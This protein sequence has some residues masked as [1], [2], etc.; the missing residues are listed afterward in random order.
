M[1]I[2]KVLNDLSLAVVTDL[3]VAVQRCQHA[4][5]AQVLA[6]RL[7]LL[8]R[9]ATGLAHLDQRVPQTVRIEVGQAGGFEAGAKDFPN[10]C[11]AGPVLRLDPGDLKSVGRTDDHL[12][13]RKQRVIVAPEFFLSQV[14]HPIDDD[15]ADLI[16]DREENVVKDLLNFVFTSRAS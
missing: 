1:R 3:P 2:S 10:R 12:R 7:E 13:G 15:L 5:V 11:G 6:P 4:F 16:A 9:L 8:G 14:I